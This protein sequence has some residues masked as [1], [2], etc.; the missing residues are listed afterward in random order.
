MYLQHLDNDH[1]NKAVE[2]TQQEVKNYERGTLPLSYRLP[3]ITTTVVQYSSVDHLTTD[4]QTQ[5]TNIIR[6]SN[7]SDDRVYAMRAPPRGNATSAPRQGPSNGGQTQVLMVIIMHVDNPT[8]IHMTV[9]S[10]KS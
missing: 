2:S 8:I 3:G 4:G 5:E 9:I 1:Y 7:N 10:T 6:N